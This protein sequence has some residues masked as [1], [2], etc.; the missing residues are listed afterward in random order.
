MEENRGE[1][2]EVAWRGDSE[3]DAARAMAS[4]ALDSWPAR[5]TGGF[6]TTASSLVRTVSQTPPLEPLDDVA[7]FHQSQSQ[8]EPGSTRKHH[9]QRHRHTA[10][11]NLPANC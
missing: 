10:E 6:W 9:A 3:D 11:T 1:E 2:G 5:M 8:K 4:Q 7:H